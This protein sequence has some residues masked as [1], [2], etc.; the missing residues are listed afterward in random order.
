ME[1]MVDRAIFLL[2]TGSH[3]VVVEKNEKAIHTEM[4]P[5]LLQCM[6]FLARALSR[7][8]RSFSFFTVGVV[9]YAVG[10]RK[11]SYNSMH[12]LY[13]VSLSLVSTSS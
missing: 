13:T 8:W 10:V 2:M 9:G 1:M 11:D 7:V 5:K 6:Y 4:R 12:G 3:S